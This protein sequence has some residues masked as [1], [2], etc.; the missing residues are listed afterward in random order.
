M[1]LARDNPEHHK[2]VIVKDGDCLDDNELH[3]RSLIRR[4]E[5]ISSIREGKAEF[6][7]RRCLP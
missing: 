1:I 2:A 6:Y 7:P 4:D 3:R 5:A